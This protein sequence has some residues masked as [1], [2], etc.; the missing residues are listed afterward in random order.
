M[1]TKEAN[2]KYITNEVYVMRANEIGVNVDEEII[3]ASNYQ[4]TFAAASRIIQTLD[5]M[6]NSL[7]QSI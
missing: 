7:I 1:T 5:E 4:K 2:Y 6:F 3:A